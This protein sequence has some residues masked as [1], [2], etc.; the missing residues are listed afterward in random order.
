MDVSESA[1]TAMKFT[2]EDNRLIKWM[3]VSKTLCSKTFVQE[4]VWQ[5]MK[6][7]QA[8]TLTQKSVRV[9]G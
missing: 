1:V 2:T 4:A 5:K 7:W 8:M 3:W 6:A 9:F